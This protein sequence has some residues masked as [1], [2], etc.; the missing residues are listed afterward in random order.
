MRTQTSDGFAARLEA[1]LGD[2]EPSRHRGAAPARSYDHI[3]CGMDQIA[4]AW[5]YLLSAE[6]EQVLALVRKLRAG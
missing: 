4:E 1:M 2:G 3:G 6:R 5:P